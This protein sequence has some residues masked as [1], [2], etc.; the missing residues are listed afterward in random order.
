[1]RAANLLKSVITGLLVIA[2]PTSIMGCPAVAAAAPDHLSATSSNQLV[3]AQ[4][5]AAA[6]AVAS[7][8]P[9]ITRSEILARAQTWLAAHVPYSQEVYRG[10]YRTDCSGFV[11]MAWKT[12]RNYWTGD[13]NTIGTPIGY[14]DLRPGDMLLYH[15]TAN[16]VNGS[17]VVLFDRWTGP[18]GGDFLIYEQTPPSTKHRTWS[19]T[20]YSRTLYKPFRYVNA[21][22]DANS[23]L[24]VL[25]FYL[26]DDPQSHVQTRPVVHYGNS[27]M[28]P[29]V[30][31]WDGDGADTVSAYDPTSGRFYLSSNPV[32]G[33]AQINI[34][35]GNPG[36]KPLV[37]DWDG[38]GKDNIG[39]RM[40]NTF[41]LRT[42]PVDQPAE[43]TATV[44]YGDPGDTPVVGDWDGDGKDNVGVYRPGLFRFYLRMNP[45]TSTGETTRVVPYGNPNADPLIGDWDGDGKDNVGVRMGNTFAFRTSPVS[46]DT[47]TTTS[48]AYGN[49]A[50]E[51][52]I[53]GDW[54]ADNK[55]TQG[56]VR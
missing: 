25:D 11:S 10:G 22:D 51:I 47:E 16:P 28:V 41:Y 5:A 24:G 23:D 15:N 55:D 49:G 4:P 27:P 56:I 21:I 33:T 53:V 2:A 18:V 12:N 13:L 52:P 19:S 30:G 39:V 43:T 40:G 48:V 38:D 26:S 45:N 8:G 32:T 54:N 6:L 17:H 7:V 50:G 36:A 14:N 34:M 9:A 35:Y 44:A 46:S 31:D 42:T 20:G 37:G 1:M 29:I 3:T